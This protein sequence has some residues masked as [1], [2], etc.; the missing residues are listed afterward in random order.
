M[1]FFKKNIK[2]LRL[3]IF[4]TLVV[5][6][7]LAIIATLLYLRTTKV[8]QWINIRLTIAN[9]D[10]WWE[11]QAP[12]YWYA[13]SLKS[14]IVSYNSWG[15]K[16]AEITDVESFDIG[17][18]RRRLYIDIRLKGSFDK[19]RQIYLYNYQPLQIGKTLDLTFGKNNI[20]GLVTYIGDSPLQYTEKQIEVKIYQVR[21]SLAFSYTKGL[22]MKDSAGRILAVI[23]Q[24]DTQPA[25]MYQFSDLRGMM[26]RVVNPDYQDVT[27]KMTIKTFTSGSG[28]YFIDRAAV[29]IGEIIWF[30]FPDTLVKEA[31][32]TKIFE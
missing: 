11:G 12:Q 13:D 10:W 3:N 5:L 19:K 20:K 27:L 32:I 26:I 14:G 22:E 17:D 9:E 4:D 25:S 28:T 6:I 29:K 16:V 18:Y 15:E 23:E 1:N 21:N 24:I 2:R 31:V 30:Q 7:I 8:S